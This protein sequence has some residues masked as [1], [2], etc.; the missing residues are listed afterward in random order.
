MGSRKRHSGKL[1]GSV[2]AG[3]YRM[4]RL[5]GSGG[6]AEVYLGRH[7]EIDSLR[8]A[9]KVLHGVHR[10]REVILDRFKREASVLALLRNRHTVRLVDYGCTEDG[11]PFLVMEYVEGAS[12]DRVIRSNGT[13]RDGDAARVG[14]DVLKALAEAH[15]AGVIHRD[16]KPANIFLVQEPSEHHAVARVLDFGIAKVMGD[17]QLDLSDDVVRVLHD[18]TGADLVFCTP[19]YA[20]PELL[21][22]RPDFRTD[23]YALGL[24]MAEMLDG[25]SPYADRDCS[26]DVSPHLESSPVPLGPR[27]STSPL[28]P[29]IARAVAKDADERY[30]S[31]VEMLA[32][33]EIAYGR[34]RNPDFREPALHIATPPPVAPPVA[35]PMAPP[36]KHL[37]LSLIPVSTTRVLAETGEIE[38]FLLT[39][40]RDSSSVPSLVVDAPVLAGTGP[41]DTV[42]SRARRRAAP[43]RWAASA[44]ALLLLGAVPALV[45]L[46]DGGPQP[47]APERPVAAENDEGA[48]AV[49]AVAA[50]ANATAVTPSVVAAS[51]PPSAPVAS[52]APMLQFDEEHEALAA[53]AAASV[54]VGAATEVEPTVL[55]AASEGASDR[56]RQRSRDRSDRSDRRSESRAAA[57]PDSASPSDSASN[58]RSSIVVAST[59]PSR[60]GPPIQP[61]TR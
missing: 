28:A 8:V 33:L 9:V 30:Q 54:R 23:L 24:L 31:A 7:K 39:E 17:P 14:I 57:S 41:E 18:Q 36:S 49:L 32:E 26:I 10:T 34:F 47:D 6:F 40:I 27:A 2:L 20:A 48:T 35:P 52:K 43:A 53:I 1:L 11:V 3:R 59:A 25:A 4:E 22:G 60:L 45:A 13:L 21:R 12:L 29:I 5:L 58:G 15:A 51:E 38:D 56:E 44:A 42:P 46:A 50:P 37:S 55:A 19:L 61:R 16:L